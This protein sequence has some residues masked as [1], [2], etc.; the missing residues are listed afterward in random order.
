MK[1]RNKLTNSVC[2][3]NEVTGIAFIKCFPEKYEEVKK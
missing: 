3:M 2:E 1:I